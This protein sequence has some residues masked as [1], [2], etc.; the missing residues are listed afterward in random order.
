MIQREAEYIGKIRSRCPQIDISKVEYNL[1][2]GTYN[3]I[4]VVND[5]Y[6]FKFPRYDWSVAFLDNEAKVINFLREYV[7]VPLPIQEPLGRDMIK[8]N[9]MKGKQVFRN[10]L[11]QMDG[12]SQESIAEQIGSFLKKLHSIPIKDV[13]NRAI[14]DYPYSECQD[15]W[16][17]RFEEIKRKVFPYC[18][19]YTKECI[20]QIF[21]PLEEDDEFMVYKPVLIHGDMSPCHLFI[22]ER[23]KKLTGV[24][25][26]GLSGLGDPAYDLGTLLDN[27][28]E[29]FLKRVGRY[30]NNMQALINRARFYAGVNNIMWM[31]DVSDMIITRDFSNL[32]FNYRERDIMPI[33]SKW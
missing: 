22:D 20:N 3:D 1:G 10:S 27:L 30:Y 24:I 19:S 28:G 9:L 5:T 12:K 23:T 25:G 31:R 21:S 16:L 33:G 18:S 13:E 2:D 7:T 29:T 8:C 17:T 14:G 32:R 4:V 15:E 11:L 26:F 6:V